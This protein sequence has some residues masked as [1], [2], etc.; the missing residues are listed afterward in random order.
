[1][2]RTCTHVHCMRTRTHTQHVGT[3]LP[4]ESLAFPFVFKSPNAGV[5][6]EVWGL[7]TG[8]VLA[9]GRPLRVVLRGVA[10]QDDL[11][12]G[13]RMEIE[14]RVP[15]TLARFIPCIRLS[16]DILFYSAHFIWC[17]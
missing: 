2:L 15:S 9:R 14:V 3:L 10:L 17:V 7:Q 5:F 6:S 1:M 11:N 16:F 8:P 12:A 4:G 13:K